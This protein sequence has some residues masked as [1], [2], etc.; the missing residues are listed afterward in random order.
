MK[1]IALFIL[2]SLL[3]FGQQ[4]PV[5]LTPEQ[6]SAA[7]AQ[8]GPSAKMVYRATS[9]MPAI[10]GG[11]LV[12]ERQVNE[13]GERI[14]L[15]YSLPGTYLIQGVTCQGAPSDLGGFEYQGPALFMPV[16]TLDTNRRFEA[17]PF[18]PNICFINTFRLSGGRVEQLGILVGSRPTI[19][20]VRVMAEA[21][22]GRGEY[23][24]TLSGVSLEATIAVGKS[25]ISLQKEQ[26]PD[27]S[28]RVVFPAGIWIPPA[29][30]TTLTICRFG[31]CETQV[32]ERRVE[33]PI[34][35]G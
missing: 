31:S 27:G 2:A 23:F 34:P 35:K 21:V 14:W 9:G 5:P 18:A 20:P 4:K 32:F 6:S 3:A 1:L 33:V 25:A 29:G 26:L 22:N 24:L 7:W 28:V 8:V 10:N 16:L 17:L 13:Y 12:T 19:P 11:A 15:I 30:P